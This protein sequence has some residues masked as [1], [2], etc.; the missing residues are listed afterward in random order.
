MPNTKKVVR[1]GKHEKKDQ[2]NKNYKLSMYY[3]FVIN[4]HIEMGGDNKC[5]Y[6]GSY[7]GL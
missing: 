3:N 7:H 4:H 2:K 5:T 6:K 1:K